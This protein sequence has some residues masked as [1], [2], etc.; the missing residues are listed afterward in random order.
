MKCLQCLI[1]SVN[2]H[3]MN[4]RIELFYLG[5]FFLTIIIDHF[6]A[7][8]ARKKPC[9][10]AV[11]TPRTVPSNVSRNTGTR[12]TN[13]SVDGNGSHNNQQT[14]SFFRQR[15]K[16]GFKKKRVSDCDETISLNLT[17]KLVKLKDVP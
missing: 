9:T 10:I 2:I 8:T 5:L 17:I 15:E 3:S 1:N 6:S 4:K 16:T 13:A 14:L 7:T 12:S 11:G